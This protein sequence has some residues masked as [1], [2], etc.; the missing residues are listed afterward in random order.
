[1][2]VFFLHRCSI[3]DESPEKYQTELAKSEE[4]KAIDSYR[5]TLMP[6]YTSNVVDLV[7]LI[8]MARKRGKA[9]LCFDVKSIDSN[10]SFSQRTGTPCSYRQPKNKGAQRRQNIGDDEIDK[11]RCGT[12]RSLVSVRGSLLRVHTVRMGKVSFVILWKRGYLSILAKTS[13]YFRTKRKQFVG[14]PI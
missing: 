11:D 10:R 1:M 2:Q 13:L 7:L 9:R 12:V 6:L 8:L 4:L 5:I 3:H 14:N